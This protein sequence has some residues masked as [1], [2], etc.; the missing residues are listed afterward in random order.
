MAREHMTQV[1][2]AVVGVACFTLL[3]AG[4]AGADPTHQLAGSP[5]PILLPL[6]VNNYA[7]PV[8]QPPDGMVVIPAGEFRM[9]CWSAS[10][11]CTADEQPLHA[12]YLDAYYIDK[13]EVTNAQYAQCVA[14]GNC[15]PPES[16]SSY[17]RATY[18]DDDAYANYP[19]IYVSWDD[20]CAYCAWAN[21][22]LPTEAE[23]EKAARGSS[24]VRT[25]PWGTKTVSCS[26]ANYYAGSHYCV[27]DTMAVGSYPPGASPYGVM[28][29]A[30]NVWEWVSDWYAEDYYSTSPYVNPLGPESGTM[31][32][33]RGGSWYNLADIVRVNL[34]HKYYPD[35][36]RF[37]V[38]FRCAADVV[39]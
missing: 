3:L 27:G 19:V 16:N 30:G 35:Y 17:M 4:S 10:G 25:Y 5:E 15:V 34:R 39:Q 2:L 21:K 36:H 20:A 28:D 8:Y 22:R 9:G 33:M 18:Y 6:L 11:D 24:D 38:G 29:M 12:V 26:L 1:F 31:R 37:S 32:V 7:A 13:Y 14:A 23:W